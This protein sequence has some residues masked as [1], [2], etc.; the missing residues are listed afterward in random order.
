[1][2]LML[3]PQR[4]DHTLL[5]TNT[6]RVLLG[7]QIPEGGT[8][9]QINGQVNAVA[10]SEITLVRGNL[11]GFAGFLMNHVDPDDASNFDSLWDERVPKDALDGA[12]VLDLD[13]IGSDSD[14]MMSIGQPDVMEMVQQGSKDL[15]QWWKE[16]HM[17]NFVGGSGGQGF[18]WV[19]MNASTYVPAIERFIRS[20]KRMRAMVPS[21]LM[22]AA[23]AP[24]TTSTTTA[25]PGTNEDMYGTIKYLGDSLKM[26]MLF[27]QGLTGAGAATLFDTLAQDIVDYLEPP[28][29]EQTAGAF[30]GA[31]WDVLSKWRVG[32]KI[33]GEMNIGAISAG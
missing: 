23:M 15:Q 28:V 29:H 27:W 18:H 7:L 1:M 9:M 30:P 33:P 22:F 13:T 19:D 26:A 6:D 32:V 8:V 31:T 5:L 11:I 4:F 20:K 24:I 17:L 16:L 14:P 12:D 3:W 2:S 10:Q 25:L 21:V